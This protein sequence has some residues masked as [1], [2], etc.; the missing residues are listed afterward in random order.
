ECPIFGIGPDDL[1]QS[2]ALDWMSKKDEVYL[3]QV[4]RALTKKIRDAGKLN[5]L[6]VLAPDQEQMAFWH[7]LI[8]HQ[9]NDLPYT[10]DGACLALGFYAVMKLRDSF[11]KGG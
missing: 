5:M 1:R 11:K 9:N 8:E 2:L 4:I 7:E 6:P 3:Q 10:T